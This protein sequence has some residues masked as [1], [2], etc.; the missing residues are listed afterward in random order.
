MIEKRENV[1]FYQKI[2]VSTI[3]NNNPMNNVASEGRVT[4]AISSPSPSWLLLPSPLS[5]ISDI[6]GTY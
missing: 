3:T 1:F 2:Y 6:Y 4:A 5:L